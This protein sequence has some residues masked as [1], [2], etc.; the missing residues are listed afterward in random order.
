MTVYV[1]G[2]N[3]ENVLWFAGL[4]EGEGHIQVQHRYGKH[5]RLRM[6]LGSCDLDVLERLQSLHG[7]VI[8]SIKPRKANWKPFWRWELS[9]THTT[10]AVAM[11][12]F[13]FMAQ[14]RRGQIA[15]AVR[16]ML[17]S[18]PGIAFSQRTRCPQGH[19][20][21]GVNVKGGRTCSLCHRAA[22]ARY[23]ARKKA[24]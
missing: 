10:Y 1:G 19:P 20:Y 24:S 11:A 14:R 3:R 2:L 9:N 5:A 7:G 23:Q 16:T 17:A 6:E 15:D 18:P 4:F 12:I 8:R 22:N 13:P 21:D